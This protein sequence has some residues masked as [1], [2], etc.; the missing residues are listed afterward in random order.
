MGVKNIRPYLKK[1]VEAKTKERT[2]LVELFEIQNYGSNQLTG[3]D[4]WMLKT[5]AE[6]D[7]YLTK[8]LKEADELSLEVE[9]PAEDEELTLDPEAPADGTDAEL[10]LDTEI[11]AEDT[12]LSLDAEAPADGTDAELSLD[13]EI[14]AE[15]TELSLDAEAPAEGGEAPAEDTPMETSVTGVGILPLIAEIQD[16]LANGKPSEVEI[17]ALKAIGKL[18]K[19]GKS[20]KSLKDMLLEAAP[21]KIKV[22]VTGIKW[23]DPDDPKVSK[24][25]SKA[26]IEVSNLDKEEIGVTL[27]KQQQVAP[28]SAT[29]TATLTWA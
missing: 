19:E 17:A 23:D 22:S 20:H 24:L 11:P 13:T 15:D 10:S 25:P 4:M 16:K 26:E 9:A 3:H 12:E 1:L 18:L 14:P 5:A 21:K 6:D 8:K 28:K 27:Y 29:V 2:D 7:K